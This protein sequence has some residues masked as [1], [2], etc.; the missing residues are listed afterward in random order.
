VKIENLNQDL[1]LIINTRI[2]DIL[3]SVLVLKLLNVYSILFL[4]G[5]DPGNCSKCHRDIY[6][7]LQNEGKKQLILYSQVMER[8][9]K[10][11]WKGVKYLPQT[12]SHYNSDTITDAQA[13]DLLERKFL[14]ES[15]FETLPLKYWE[16]N[17]NPP[18]IEPTEENKPKKNKKK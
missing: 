16:N 12:A 11:K 13:L 18:T 3:N 7:K 4:N 17:Q 6:R 8:T 15:D 2:E 1:E 9:N 14:K 5:K 10:P